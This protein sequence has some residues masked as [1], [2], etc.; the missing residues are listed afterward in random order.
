MGVR[1]VVAAGWAVDDDAAK[2]FA[3]TLYDRLLGGYAFGKAVHEA[4]IAAYQQFPRSNTWGAYQCYGDPHWKLVRD[5]GDLP[6]S[7][8]A[9]LFASPSQAA[10]ELQNL[11]AQ[12]R[13]RALAPEAGR[14]R[15]KGLVSQLEKAR[16][17][18]DPLVLAPL[19]RAYGEALL[20]SDAIACFRAALLMDRAHVSVSDIEMLAN[21][22]ARDAIRIAREGKPTGKEAQR[23]ALAQVDTAIRRLEALAAVAAAE[24]GTPQAT[25]DD[26]TTIERLALLASAY[27]R[28]AWISA[29]PKERL[30]AL[31]R[32]HDYYRRAY[33]RKNDLYPF[34]NL[35]AAEIVLGWHKR[36]PL[37]A[38][39][40]RLLATDLP[41]R[42][43]SLLEAFEQDRSFWNS[44]MLADL[45]LFE[46]LGGNSLSTEVLEKVATGYK[47]AAERGSLRELASVLE[48]LDF[49]AALAMQAQPRVHR[50]LRQ[51]REQL[52][53]TGKTAAT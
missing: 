6:G 26:G 39:L 3:Q 51:L 19:G 35:L 33:R 30:S 38:D 4:R 32:C 37:R 5:A 31:D 10:V 8:E 45:D 47:A 36:K 52:P 23:R 50:W 28:K 16:F 11:S 48:Q 20:P 25:E 53:G 21:L 41:L 12:L 22:E 13:T 24:R 42:R 17:L 9:R 43:T 14:E 18:S 7:T 44:A 1:A 34:L 46:A 49:L 15:L 29:T 2:L 27:K 40:Q